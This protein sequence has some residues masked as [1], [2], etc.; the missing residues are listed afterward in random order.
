MLPKQNPYFLVF[1]NGIFKGTGRK[2]DVWWLPLGGSDI[3]WPLFN[4]RHQKAFT[5]CPVVAAAYLCCGIKFHPA[6]WL[7]ESL[8]GH[9]IQHDLP[10]EN[11]LNCD[12]V[13]FPN[14]I[15]NIFITF[16]ANHFITKSTENERKSRFYRTYQWYNLRSTILK[17]QKKHNA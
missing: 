1:S 12:S 15:D 11:T 8:S 17:R 10:T 16:P 2:A 9:F 7:E 6:L 5:R 14:R 3:L 13:L 4:H